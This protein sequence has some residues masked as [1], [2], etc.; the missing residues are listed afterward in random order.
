LVGVNG[1]ARRA[2]QTIELDDGA[3]INRA[4]WWNFWLFGFAVSTAM[5]T[6]TVAFFFLFL[7][8]RFAVA[9]FLFLFLLRLAMAFFA[10]VA[11]AMLFFGFRLF[12]LLGRGLRDFFGLFKFRFGHAL[13]DVATSAFDA[14]LFHVLHLRGRGRFFF[15]LFV[16]IGPCGRTGPQAQNQTQAQK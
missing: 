5:T 4:D 2:V 14:G 3:L 12:R 10:A 15:F 7:F 9:L 13:V 8:L 16:T 1:F 6:T 11:T